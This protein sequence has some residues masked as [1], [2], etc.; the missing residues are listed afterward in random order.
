[1]HRDCVSGIT[2]GGG[3]FMKTC[4]HFCSIP[5][6]SCEQNL[7]QTSQ[8]IAND[9]K[10]AAL[11]VQGLRFTVY[12]L[13]LRVEGLGLRGEGL[14]LRVENEGFSLFCGFKA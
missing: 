4:L 9:V 5:R 6:G 7:M 13:M 2:R 12:G 11:T 8:F 3:H 1:M 10:T 14:E